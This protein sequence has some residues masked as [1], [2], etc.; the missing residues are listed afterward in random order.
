MGYEIGAQIRHYRELRGLTQKDLAVQIGVSNSRIS[1][2]EQGINRPDVDTLILIC[3]TL[4]VSAD[5]L[6]SLTDVNEMLTDDERQLISQ[7]RAKPDLQQAVRILLG[8]CD[9]KVSRKT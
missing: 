8:I 4:D 3:Q 5:S 2:W 6:L 1:N 7:Y 9:S